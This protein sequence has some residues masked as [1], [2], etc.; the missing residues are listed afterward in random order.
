MLVFIDRLRFVYRS[1]Q[2]FGIHTRAVTVSRPRRRKGCFQAAHI[3]LIAEQIHVIH[4][5]LGM[6]GRPTPRW[7][8]PMRIFR[9]FVPLSV[10]IARPF[11]RLHGEIFHVGNRSGSVIRQPGQQA[12]SGTGRT[13]V[14]IS[15]RQTV[16]SF[17]KGHTLEY[18][19]RMP[20]PVV[21]PSAPPSEPS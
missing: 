9:W 21:N 12:V 20:Q 3:H 13:H 16:S 4:Q 10:K 11:S 1:F 8:K 15:R 14:I 19:S 17:R 6:V 18:T 7:P 2:F 5:N